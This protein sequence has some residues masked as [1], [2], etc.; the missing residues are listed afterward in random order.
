M[1]EIQKIKDR[2]T[3]IKRTLKPWRGMTW[4]EAQKHG[5]GKKEKKLQQELWYLGY[6]LHQIEKLRGN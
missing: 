1:N 5:F 4:K 6:T 3:K 2:I